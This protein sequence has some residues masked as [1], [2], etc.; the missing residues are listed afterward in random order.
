MNK[1][2]LSG[3]RIISKLQEVM[4]TG[5]TT[6]P[7]TLDLEGFLKHLQGIKVAP[8]CGFSVYVND[9][10]G[11]DEKTDVATISDLQIRTRRT[12]YL[13]HED[14]SSPST[15]PL[16]NYPGFH[17]L[18]D[19]IIEIFP[20]DSIKFGPCALQDRYLA[21]HGK[22]DGQDW[23]RDGDTDILVIIWVAT[24]H[25]KGGE[26]GLSRLPDDL[27]EKAKTERI[28]L[29][30]HN[31]GVELYDPHTFK[32]ALVFDNGVHRHKVCPL[33]NTGNTVERRLSLTLS[34]RIKG[35][36][37]TEQN[38]ETRDCIYEMTRYKLEEKLKEWKARQPHTSVRSK[39]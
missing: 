19:S 16:I 26:L 20:K 3:P 4:E 31:E 23:H 32:Q 30:D 39:L 11:V 28:K 1:K 5:K 34:L 8:G 14:Q 18:L 36:R 7:T 15:P 33:T 21:P 25:A 10:D 12:V 38:E 17:E 35:Q 29:P 6:L 2:L 9:V 27:I 22:Q 24:P 37:M 13:L